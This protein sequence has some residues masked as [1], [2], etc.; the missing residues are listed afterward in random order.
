MSVSR[1]LAALAAFA[2][3]GAPAAAQTVLNGNVSDGAGGPLLGGVVYHVPFSMNVPIGATLTIQPGAI[4][5]LGTGATFNVNGTLLAGGATGQP[6]II[7]SLKDDSAGGDTN[8]DGVSSGAPGD[9][10]YM[11]FT[12]S[13]AASDLQSVTVRYGGGGGWNPVRLDNCAATFRECTVENGLNSG[14]HLTNSMAQPTIADCTIRNNTGWAI[15]GARFENVLNLSNNSATGNGVNS[16]LINDSSLAADAVVHARCGING[17]LTSL[18]TVNVPGGRTLSLRRGVVLKFIQNASFSVN[19]TLDCQ[20]TSG[21]PVVITTFA[22]DAFG[23]DTNGDGPSSGTPGSWSM[24]RF[25]AGSSGSTLTNT[26]LR[27][28]G[29]GGWSPVRVEN[30]GPTLTS[31]TIENAVGVGVVLASVDGAPTIQGCTVRNNAGWAV[32]AQ[33]FESI[34]NLAGN[35]ATGNGANGLLLMS[36][37]PSSGLVIGPQ[38]GFS[39]TLCLLTTLS[40]NAG[41][42]LTLQA[43]TILK[44]VQSMAYEISGTL[45][46][47]GTAAQ[48]VVFTTFSDDEYGGDSNTNGASLG[49][50]GAWAMIRFSPGSEASRLTHALVRYGGGGGWNPIYIQGGSPTLERCT[51]ERGVNSGISLA[52]TPTQARIDDCTVRDCSGAA[53][54]GVPVNSLAYITR[55][56]ASGNGANQV[57][58]Q[59]GT[60][61][62]DLYLDGNTGLG[63]AIVVYTTLSVPVGRKLTLGPGAVVKLFTSQRIDV[64]GALDVVATRERPAVITAHSDDSFG[65]DSDGAG[66]P[67]APG[68]WV[69]LLLDANAAPSRIENL[70]LRYGGGGGWSALRANSPLAEYR[71]VRVERA[72]FTGFEMANAARAEFLTAWS[73]GATG[74][75]L[76]GG[77]FALLRATAA[78]CTTGVARTGAYSGS[79]RSSIAWGNT[80]ANFS[81]LLPNQASYCNGIPGG[82]NFNLDVSPQFAGALGGDLALLASSPCINAGDPAAPQDAD[83]TRADM[84]SAPSNASPTLYCA[85]KTNSFGCTPYLGYSGFARATLSDPLVVRSFNVLNDKFGLFFYGYAGRASA[86]FQGGLKCVSDPVVRTPTQSSGGIVGFTNCSGVFTLDL[87]ARMNSGVDPLLAPGAT[88]AV[89]CWYRDASAAFGT[90]LSNAL[91]LSICN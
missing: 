43:G 60:L 66:S 24:V 91:E 77:N 19:G 65:G 63:G 13:A 75:A 9:W 67:P 83:C 87:S 22:D 36:S 69:W 85:G 52:N 40:L 78:N 18:A 20:G 44:P 57:Q 2:A 49:T 38:M 79:I 59:G 8:G 30:A 50:P 32:Q 89:Q 80:N 68:Q 51:I 70:L 28:G 74:I 35:T 39:N 11:R 54:T 25:N 42:T 41:R 55:L 58:I 76:T 33:G 45:L 10:I 17:V 14:F 12:A 29:G 82:A 61:T 48:P 53:L 27:F 21:Q 64:N 6:V 46:A 26:R 84:G 7:T 5:K 31:C 37:A 73:C 16:V 72:A 3:L 4:V 88:L 34:V 23:G 90:G 71:H 56:K 86:P 1:L 62:S 47:N 81:G 15:E